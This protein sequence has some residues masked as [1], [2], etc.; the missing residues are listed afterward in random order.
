MQHFDKNIKDKDNISNKTSVKINFINS[1]QHT[2]LGQTRLALV[3]PSLLNLRKT[4]KVPQKVVAL[5]SAAINESLI[6]KLFKLRT[7]NLTI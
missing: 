6:F 1:I 2:R 5:T 4:N 7:K 3:K